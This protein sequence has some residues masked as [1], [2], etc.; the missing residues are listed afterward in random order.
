MSLALTRDFRQSARALRRTPAFTFAV[1]MT[2]ALCLDPNIAILAMIDRIVVRPLSFPHGEQLVQI[3]NAAEKN[4]GQTIGSGFPQWIDFKANAGLFSGF[5]LTR[6]LGFTVGDSDGIPQRLIGSQVSANFFDV[7]GI[8]PLLGNFFAPEDEGEI[9]ARVLVLTQSYWESQYNADPKVIGTKVYGGGDSY[10]IIG[11]APRSVEAL[12]AQAK[13]F[14]L[15]NFEPRRLRPGARYWGGTLL[16][17][18]LKENV[19]PT[20]ALS[21]L[22]ALEETF[23][24]DV[25]SPQLRAELDREGYGLR[26]APLTGARPTTLPKQLWMLQAGAALLL[27]IG[28]VNAANLLLARANARRPE[29]AVRHALGAGRGTLFR[30][31]WTES[32]WLTIT[33]AALGLLGA[34][35]LLAAVNHF[36][37]AIAPTIPSVHLSWMVVGLA[38]AAALVISLAI[39][40]I[41]ALWLHF[42]RPTLVNSRTETAARWSRHLVGGLVAAQTALALVLLFGAG[43]LIHS[44][45]KVMAVDPGFDPSRIMQ[46]RIALHGYDGVA[47]NAAVQSRILAAMREIP[48]VEKVCF[49]TDMGM[50]PSFRSYPFLFRRAEMMT[51]ENAP[52][53]HVEGVTTDYFSTMGMRVLQGEIFR[54]T[55]D[56]PIRR[57][58]VVDT[59]FVKR[60]LHGGNAVGVEMSVGAVAPPDGEWPH[61]IGVVSA[62]KVSGPE[63]DNTPFVYIPVK[64]QLGGGVTMLIRTARSL[65][66]VMR[67]V[68]LKLREIDPRLPLY[69]TGTFEQAIDDLLVYRRAMMLLLGAFAF[70]ALSLSGIGV[71]GMLSYDVTQRTREIGI[72]NAIGATRAQILRLIMKQGLRIAC[73][74]LTIGI[75]VALYFG[76]FLQSQLFELNSYDPRTFAAVAVLLVTVSALACW[77]P[78]RKAAKVDPSVALRAE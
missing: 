9:S 54:D 71:Y 75:V 5:A 8:R 30:Q 44:F 11:V 40:V 17:G 4:G 60:Y 23:R 21:Q 77:L 26:M 59:E 53:A 69:T 14:F 27:V 16:I 70:L 51:E 15:Q 35:G 49:V 24:R 78:A 46:G 55:D 42:L 20:A 29:Y 3:T 67:D 2:L 7:L 52:K 39:G 63:G 68:R 72:R 66:D 48:G 13:L 45:V 74:G 65:T 1:I 12:D 64:Q 56:P 50:A 31:I 58:V 57:S 18:R 22:T 33:G 76:R 47:A 28:C 43:L 6:S 73:A 37:P 34:W 25:A 62:V 61:I 19:A 36:L 41:P 10:T 38:C 32:A